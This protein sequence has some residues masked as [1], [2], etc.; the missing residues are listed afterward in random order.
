MERYKLSESE[1]FAMLQRTAEH[2]AVSVRL[3]A[4]EL[5][6]HAEEASSPRWPGRA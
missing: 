4:K 6:A 1:A 5:V 3:V 2:R